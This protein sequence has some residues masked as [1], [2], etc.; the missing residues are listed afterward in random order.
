MIYLVR[1]INPRNK[2]QSRRA[3]VSVSRECH[4]LNAS[5]RARV[6]QLPEHEIVRQSH[7]RSGRYE[8]HYFALKTFPELH[9]ILATAMALAS[10]ILSCPKEALQIGWWLNVMRPGDVTFPHTHND[11]DELLS[12]AY[13]IDTPSGSGQFVLID[14]AWREEIEACPGIFVFFA[15]D[16]LHEVTRNESDYWR[17]SVG[18]NLG[19][20]KTP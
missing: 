8:N 15:P 6:R 7:Y 19:P 12:G 17:I 2:K 9:T 18:F 14:G 16:V 5:L 4:A 3:A 13:Y 20:A 10:S 1:A 11:N